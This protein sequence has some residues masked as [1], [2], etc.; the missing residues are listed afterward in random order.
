MP[1]LIIPQTWQVAKKALCIGVQYHA[2]AAKHPSEQYL[3]LN[4]THHDPLMIRDLL[5]DKLGF[6]R[7]DITVLMDDGEHV[8]PTRENII[9]PWR[10]S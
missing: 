1:A 9:V 2:L 3:E 7:K 8:E 6:S 10:L 5:I 4:G